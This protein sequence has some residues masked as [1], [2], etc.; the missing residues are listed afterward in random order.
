[1]AH[2]VQLA[3]AAFGFGAVVGSVVLGSTIRRAAKWPSVVGEVVRL[4]RTAETDPRNRPAR[5]AYRYVVEGKA[6]ESE[7]FSLDPLSRIF[8]T[9]DALLT[10]YPVGRPVRVFYDPVRPEFAIVERASQRTAWA[11]GLVGLLVM[12]FALSLSD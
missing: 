6:L 3:M 5:V 1:M 2:A 7:Q 11:I 12:G 9:R 4:N 8:S 10:S